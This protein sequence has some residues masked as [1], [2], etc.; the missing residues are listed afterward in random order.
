MFS[1]LVARTFV[2]ILQST[3]IRLT[4]LKLPGS[5]GSLSFLR[6]K[7]IK[8]S[9]NGFDRF[10]TENDSYTLL[11][12]WEPVCHYIPCNIK[13]S[14]PGDFP[15]LIDEMALLTSSTDIGR[16]NDSF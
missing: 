3:L 6:I 11:L 12:R 1:S 2:M 13:P 9:L 4:G 5:V 8:A 16:S 15:A 7:D 10:P 14:K